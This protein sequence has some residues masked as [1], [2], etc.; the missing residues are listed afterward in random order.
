MTYIRKNHF[1][2]P[3]H[4]DATGVQLGARY[5]GSPLIVPDGN[6]PEDVFPETYDEYVPS[7]LPGGRA[8]HLW[9]DAERVMGSSLYDRFGKGFTLLRLNGSALATDA[10]EHAAA[11]DGHSAHGARCADAGGARNSTAA[12]S[13]WSGRTAHR[14]ARRRRSR[15]CRARS[16]TSSPA[17]L[18]RAE[19]GRPE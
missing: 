16:S 11:A 4:V 15:R 3:E 17:A 18:P 2:R 9:L 1:C 19:R 13:S 7:G 12:T 8:P 10:F 6:P 14:L 5:D